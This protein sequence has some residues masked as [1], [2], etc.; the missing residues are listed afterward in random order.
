MS[1][2]AQIMN[3][4]K[5]AMK[6]KDKETLGTVRMLSAAIKQVEVDERRELSDADILAIVTKMVK[7]RKDA[8]EQFAQAERT[9]LEVKELA[10]IKIL[11]VYLPE[12]LSA[13]DVTAIV[14]SIIVETE[15][16]GMQDMGKV[17][18]LVK[19]K[20]AGQADMGQV[21]QIVKAA[22]S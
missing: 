13:E 18:G 15:A 19:A 14:Q 21:G 12:Q 2:K 22:L 9:D 1:L 3:D 8:A 5:T 20:V 16:K 17:M 11:E 6:A 7:Q 4:I 10:E